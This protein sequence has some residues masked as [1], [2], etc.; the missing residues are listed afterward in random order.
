MFYVLGAFVLLVCL[1]I[2]SESEVFN[3][4]CIIS[5]VDGNKYCVRD[6]LKLKE[7]ADLPASVTKGAQKFVTE[8][9]TKFPDDKRVQRLVKGYDPKKVSETLPTSELT[10]FSENK[11]EKLAFCLAKTKH[12]ER[13]ID[14]NT[15]TFV[16]IHELAHIM[17]KS[18]GHKKDFWDNFKFL[19]VESKEMKFYKPI[20]YKKNNQTYC[21]MTISDNPYFDL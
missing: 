8:L 10:A 5:G 6:R 2:C 3:L 20:D 13:L 14:K 19:L 16:Y 1:K 17:T 4:R 15:L 18:V 7:A 12:S 11:G 21:G 9:G